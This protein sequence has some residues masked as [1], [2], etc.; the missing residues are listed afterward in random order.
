VLGERTRLLT[1][2]AVFEELE[3]AFFPAFADGFS[4]D[5]LRIERGRFDDFVEFVELLET[6]STPILPGI[7][8]EIRHNW[9]PTPTLGLKLI[10]S[11][12]AVALGGDTCFRPP[13]LHELRRRGILDEERFRRLTGD[14][15]WSADVIY[16]EA[17]REESGPHTSE[18][19]LLGL[20][21]QVRR[22]IRLVHVAD[23]FASDH[24]PVALEGEKVIVAPGAGAVIQGP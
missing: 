11:G 13:L 23:D 9:H 8:A 4:T 17:T 14:W 10:C 5:L 22:R 20:P 6:A 1:S 3:K 15:L 16:H 19:S 12:G 18:L 21:T 7:R 2:R 24:F